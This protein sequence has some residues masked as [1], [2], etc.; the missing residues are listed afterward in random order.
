MKKNETKKEFISFKNDFAFK[1]VMKNEKVLR[2]FLGAVL[3]I[4]PTI[5][6][7][8]QYNDTHLDKM[9]AKDKQGIMDINARITVNHT[10]RINIELQVKP[11]KYWIN[12][13]LFYDL[14]QFVEQGRSGDRYD[15]FESC[16]HIG[17]LG[18]T[19]DNLKPKFYSRFR[20]LDDE[21]YE[22]LSDKIVLHMIQLNQL[23]HVKDEHKDLLY[24]WAS[25]INAQSQEEYEMIA[26]HDEYLSEAI[27]ILDELNRD[28][29]LKQAYF[30][31][32]MAIMD[33]E[34]QKHAFYEDGLEKGQVLLS[35]LIAC[36]IEDN[37]F[38]KV[39]EVTQNV[40]L[41]DELYKKYSIQ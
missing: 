3:K 18:F 9:F 25:L 11:F 4:D 30:R 20:I 26:K 32:Q 29:A 35:K 37:Q 24:L 8:I 39:I 12:R 19:P 22:V 40:E 31:R 23:K 1:H 6:T 38:D 36:L 28:P 33:E 10:I 2:G 13:S 14:T 5:I 15:L 21:T 7:N 17:V 27:D 16:I 34:T 41:R